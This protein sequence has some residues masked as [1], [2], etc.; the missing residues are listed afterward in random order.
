MSTNISPEGRW[1]EWVFGRHLSMK[2]VMRGPS[3]FGRPAL[4]ALAKPRK[5]APALAM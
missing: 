5:P 3:M 2:A 1:K 4:I